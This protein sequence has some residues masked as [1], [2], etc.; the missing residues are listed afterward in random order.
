MVIDGDGHCNEP[1]DLFENYL[2]KEFRDR[3]PKVVDAS[4]LRWMVEGKLLPRPLGIWGHGSAS[5]FF[6]TGMKAK[7]M[8]ATRGRHGT[9]GNGGNRDHGAEKSRRSVLR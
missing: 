4:G 8:A 5:G 3:G 6:G 7:G 2:E 9:G 1:K